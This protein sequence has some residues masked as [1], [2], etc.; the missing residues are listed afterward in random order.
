ME[1]ESSYPLEKVVFEGSVDTTLVNL[2]SQDECPNSLSNKQVRDQNHRRR[3]AKQ[4]EKETWEG[5]VL[6]G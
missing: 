1:G 6:Q 3:S 4:R 2:V 5:H